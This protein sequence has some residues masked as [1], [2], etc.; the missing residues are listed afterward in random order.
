MKEIVN[1]NELTS[2]V[3]ILPYFGQFNNYFPYYLLSCASNPSID[4]LIYTDNDKDYH[5][6]DNVR[7][8]KTTFEKF[9]NRI[10]ANFS[11]R[12]GLER[13]YKLCDFKPTYGEALND[14][15]KGYDFWG[16]CDCDLIFGNIR[17]FITEDIFQKNDKIFSRG[18]LT[19]YRNVSEVNSFYR[20]QTNFD[21]VKIL[22]DTKSYSFDEYPYMSNAWNMSDSPVFDELLFDDIRPGMDGLRPSKELKGGKSGPYHEGQTDTSSEYKKMRHICYEMDYELPKLQRVYIKNNSLLK[23]E[24][25]YVHFQKRNLFL[26][27]EMIT[28]FEANYKHI[29]IVPNKII[30]SQTVEAYTVRK[31]KPAHYSVKDIKNKFITLIKR[32]TKF[33]LRIR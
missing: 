23:S 18:H 3:L 27:K 15:I 24:V 14:D 12:I 13:P 8:I 17:K 20:T 26:G 21:W 31:I 19:L 11:F 7:V 1:S 5:Y 29:L 9:K 30:P 28:D 32:G 33:L 25:L 22:S 6:P 16:H 4:W 2:V 10:Q